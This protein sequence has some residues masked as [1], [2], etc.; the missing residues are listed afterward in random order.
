MRMQGRPGTVLTPAGAAKLRKVGPRPRPVRRWG[1]DR[2]RRY[3]HHACHARRGYEVNCA[4]RTDIPGAKEP[5][6]AGP[7]AD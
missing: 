3:T 4:A 7:S 6:I 5:V 1:G 2:Y